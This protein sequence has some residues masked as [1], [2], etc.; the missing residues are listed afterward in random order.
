MCRLVKLFR[1]W[2]KKNIAFVL[3]AEKK[4]L[5]MA[6]GV[7]EK[8]KNRKRLTEMPGIVSRWKGRIFLACM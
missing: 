1:G 6:A 2:I 7:Q 5:Q 3:Q 4:V 8:W